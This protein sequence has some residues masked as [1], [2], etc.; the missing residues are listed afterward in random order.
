MIENEN[1]G[2]GK[3]L[4]DWAIQSKLLRIALG[5]DVSNIKE[6]LFSFLMRDGDRKEKAA[7][8]LYE[9]LWSAHRCFGPIPPIDLL[10]SFEREQVFYKDYRDHTMHLLTTCLLGLYIYENNQT[11]RN[12]VNQFIVTKC[13]TTL[14][15]IDETFVSAWLLTSLYHDIG[16]LVE[17]NKLEREDKLKN[18]VMDAFR[19]QISNPLASTPYYK[20]LKISKQKETK[21]NNDHGIKVRGFQSVDFYE[22]DEYFNCFI[23]SSEAS[24]LGIS[25][26]NGVKA[27]YDFCK[28]H[29]EKLRD[30]TFRDHG[31]CSALLLLY[32][33]N[34]FCKYVH[35][36]VAKDDYR[37]YYKTCHEKIAELN[38]ELK[39]FKPIVEVAAQA[40]SLHNISKTIGSKEEIIESLIDLD[41]FSVTLNQNNNDF[42]PFAFLLRM[43]DELQVW[44]RPRF[45]PA[46][47]SDDN[48]YSSDMSVFVS[49][50]AIFLR[51]FADE[52]EYVHPDTNKYSRFSKLKS[53]LLEYLDNDDVNALIKYGKPSNDPPAKRA[54][55]KKEVANRSGLSIWLPDAE[56]ADDEQTRFNSYTS[57]DDVKKFLR[58]DSD[59]LGI[60]S[61]K[62]IGKTFVLQVKRVKCSRKYKCLPDCKIPSIQ[63]NW[64]TE[65]ITIENYSTL[66][67]NNTYDDL[68]LM[69]VNAI[70]V[71][72]INFL[73]KELNG[74]N[75]NKIGSNVFATKNNNN[76]L[77]DLLFS[78][79]T[80]EDDMSLNRVV[81]NILSEKQ[82]YN[83]W[84]DNG[85]KLENICNALFYER[86]K[87]KSNPKDIAIF[88][89]K[90]DQAI[91]QTNAE[92]ADCAKCSKR[93]GY[94]KCSNPLKGT[95][96][97]VSECNNKICCYGC[98]K[99][100]SSYSSTGLRVYDELNPAKLIHIN[101]W[102]YLQLAL[103]YAATK[104]FDL[105]NGRIRVYYTM[106]KEAF[107]CEE[108]RLG[109]QN[110][111]IKSR[112]L[113]LKYTYAE[114]QRIYYESIQNQDDSLLYDAKYKHIHGRQDYAFVGVNKLC[115]P[116]CL[117]QDNSHMTETVF[118]CI[119]RHSFDRSRDVQRYGEY[120]TSKLKDEIINCIS[121]KDR[122]ETVK[123]AIEELA[124][125]LAYCEKSSDV[126]ANDSYYT[127]KLKYLP[128]YW[129]DSSNFETLL[130]MIDRNLLFEEDCQKICSRLNGLE[131]CPIEGCKSNTCIHHP[132][133]VLYKMGYLGDLKHNANNERMDEQ[134]FLDAGDI[135]YFVE[136]DDLK[137][138]NRVAYIVHP[139]LSKAIE[140]KYNKSFKHFKGF[141][142]GK[143]LQVDSSVVIQMLNDKTILSKEA[144]LQKYFSNP[145]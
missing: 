110:Q 94:E 9:M 50:S 3:E 114:Q 69:W 60:A 49:D 16:Y 68:V 59:Y 135:S 92:P 8:T 90:I 17:N 142:L 106:R 25:G 61:V 77:H 122:E 26:T 31:I 141:I 47:V 107:S 96:Y 86:K 52:E 93:N 36:L 133:T 48:L 57:T 13:T 118:E 130:S 120:L 136:A 117:K 30:D 15:G 78:L 132:F 66:L 121:E 67:T 4:F 53:I 10:R 5:N 111:K 32:C 7:S 6:Q 63:N 54:K 42:M 62:G 126:S 85:I 87:Q 112:T 144:F 88:I 38:D 101:V 71:Y 119:Y 23:Q 1:I 35:E 41:A 99:Y 95:Q 108:N 33:W 29:V 12:S 14:L 143:G 131:A 40:I 113:L 34:A 65:N 44:D 129:A 45:R 109:E 21:F 125:T 55:K 89:D 46:L 73:I 128:N 27:Y 145:Q 58:P 123:K 39:L 127:E 22:V 18:R 43:C 139:A 140:R 2:V 24:N 104:I 100:A 75:K 137:S 74:I 91:M 83:L 70:K 79:C 124:A 84:D 51:F 20:K 138:N 19:G 56:K 28:S 97:C 82:W 134:I 81:R 64:A 102:Q 115:H 37:K 11:I 76:P 105:F 98:E 116:Y 80:D 103:M 72:V